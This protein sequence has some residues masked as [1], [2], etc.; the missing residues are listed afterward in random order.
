[1]VSSFA[2]NPYT[3]TY[4]FYP[5]NFVSGQYFG[6]FPLITDSVMFISANNDESNGEA[7]GSIYYYRKINNSWVFIRQISPSDGKPRGSFGI[8][9]YLKNNCLYVGSVDGVY[10][11]DYIN[12]DWIERKK[13]IPNNQFAYNFGRSIIEFNDQLFIGAELDSRFFVEGAGSVHVYN[14]NSNGEWELSQMIYSK[15]QKFYAYF[16]YKLEINTTSQHLFIAA[17]MD[18]NDVGYFAGNVYV[19]SKFDSLWEVTQILSPDNSDQFPYFGASLATKGNY[20]FVGASG[21]MSTQTGGSIYVYK[22]INNYWQFLKKIPSPINIR[23]DYFGYSIVVQG[24]TILVGSPGSQTDGKRIAKVYLYL[25]KNDDFELKYEFEPNDSNYYDGFGIGISMNKGEILIGA[26][27]GK[28]NNISTGRAY[29]YSLF[30]MSNNDRFDKLDNYL[31]SQN[32]PNPFSSGG[33]SA[34][35]GNSSTMIEYTIKDKQFVTLKVYDMLGREVAVLVNDERAAGRYKVEFNASGLS[36]GVYVY[37]LTAGTFV[38]SKK[39]M[40]VK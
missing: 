18:S 22:L 15:N 2:Q 9:I 32:Y 16:G 21:S 25:Q 1:M 33:G 6:Y 23:R 26:K 24:D 10:I 27:D 35:G 20:L 19:L 28:N 12:N 7:S 8:P 5:H 36:S 17:P 40:I 30:P 14:K 3:Y 37:I 34:Y 39:M 29:L 38:S 11:F 4:I 13:I 31:L